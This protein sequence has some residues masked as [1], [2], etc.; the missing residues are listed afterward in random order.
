MQDVAI[1][2]IICEIQGK[3]ERGLIGPGKAIWQAIKGEE[4]SMRPLTGLTPVAQEPKPKNGSKSRGTPHTNLMFSSRTSRDG[5]R[6]GNESSRRRHQV[7]RDGRPGRVAKSEEEQKEE[8]IHGKGRKKRGFKEKESAA[9]EK[10][11]EVVTQVKESNHGD[12]TIVG[13]DA[14]VPDVD[15]VDADCMH[16][17]E[18]REIVIATGQ[19]V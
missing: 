2:D 15:M 8:C 19:W 11:A 12:G 7:G 5:K 4:P 18:P 14:D 6:G 3:D 10:L 13:S 9:E 16:S 1:H 17:A